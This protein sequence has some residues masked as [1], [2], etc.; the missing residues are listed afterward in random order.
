M[1][2]NVLG[3]RHPVLLNRRGQEAGG[4]IPYPYWPTLLLSRMTQHLI[5]LTNEAGKC[6]TRSRLLDKER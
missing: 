2:L 6:C 4:G 1:A 3:S 5:S